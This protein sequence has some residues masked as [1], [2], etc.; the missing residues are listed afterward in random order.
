MSHPFE[1][2]DEVFLPRIVSSVPTTPEEE[3]VALNSTQIRRAKRNLP[4]AQRRELTPLQE[5]REVLKTVKACQEVKK[6]LEKSMESCQEE[7][8]NI[9]ERLDELAE[10]LDDSSERLTNIIDQVEF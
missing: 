7:I 6:E 4:H 2:E 1:G 10:L 5:L 9:V 8:Q 3:A